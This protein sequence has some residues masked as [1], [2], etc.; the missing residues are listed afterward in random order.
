MKHELI[1]GVPIFRYHLESNKIKEIAKEKFSVYNE[2]PINEAPPGWQCSLR[3]EFNTSKDNVYQD[4]YSGVMDQ[5]TKDLALENCRAYIDE[6]WLNYYI[7]SENQE[8]HDHLP[9]FY[10]G[11]HFIKYDDGHTATRFVNPIY[12]LYSFMYKDIDL[13]KNPDFGSQHWSPEVK[14]GDIIIFPSFLRHLVAPQKSDEHRITLAFN[15]NTIKAS[16]RRVFQD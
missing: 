4:L 12:Q 3:T 5:F 1:F 13:Y 9:G 15:I 16:T 11:I 2:Y 6:S 8:E 14:E 10:S 7:G